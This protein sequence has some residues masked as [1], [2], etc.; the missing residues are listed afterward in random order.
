[1]TEKLCSTEKALILH[2][3]LLARENSHTQRSNQRDLL[4]QTE[5]SGFIK[6]IYFI[7]MKFFYYLKK[8]EYYFKNVSA[9]EKVQLDK[10]V[11]KSKK[12][13]LLSSF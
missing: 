3:F 4:S 10:R 5:L 8:I 9:N 12:Q 7:I 13:C 6:N 11:I 1:M 2:L